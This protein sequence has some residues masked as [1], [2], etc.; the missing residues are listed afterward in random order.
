MIKWIRA[1]RLS[2]KNSLPGAWREGREGECVEEEKARVF[3]IKSKMAAVYRGTSLIRNC[4]DLGPYSRDMS[5]ALWR[6]WEGG[7]FLMNEV[8]LYSLP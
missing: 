4:A 8:P 1:S 5:R 7:L 2:I 3:Q 6:S